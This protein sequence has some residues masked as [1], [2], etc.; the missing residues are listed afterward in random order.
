MTGR[1][2]RAGSGAKKQKLREEAAAEEAQRAE[3]VAKQ[4]DAR[5]K[6][7]EP[8]DGEAA[9]VPVPKRRRR[10]GRKKAKRVAHGAYGTPVDSA[11]G[12]PESLADSPVADSLEMRALARGWLLDE[13]ESTAKLRQ[14]LMLRVM[15][16]GIQTHDES[17]QI[18]ALR[19]ISNAEL[20][21][22]QIRILALQKSQLPGQVNI[23]V[24]VDSG[25]GSAA[26]APKPYEVIQDLLQRNEIRD[27]LVGVD[28]KEKTS[29]GEDRESDR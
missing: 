27:A 3:K 17:I 13:G 19:A 29:D 10:A 8:V 22:Q 16:T 1:R 14:A 15:Q 25:G 18:A 21:Q 12:L 23:G 6:A 2:R 20:K 24:N 9:A 5:V 7:G 28:P 4:I 26:E 11:S